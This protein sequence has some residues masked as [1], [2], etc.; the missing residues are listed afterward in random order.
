MLVRVIRQPLGKIDGVPLARYRP[1]QTYDLAPALADY[2]VL[3]GC[4]LIEMRRGDRSKRLRPNDRRMKGVP[5][6]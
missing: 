6:S 3:Q 1:G 2:L 4:A 5:E